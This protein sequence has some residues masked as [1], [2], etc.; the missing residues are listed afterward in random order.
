MT[1]KKK[2]PVSAS[3]PKSVPVSRKR[4]WMAPLALCVLTLLAFSNS[5]TNGFA[6]DS[7]MLLLGDP[8]IQQAIADNIGLIL[9]H[10]YW[11]PNGEAGL[12]RPLATLSYLFNYAVLGNGNQ[13]AG[14]HWI[15]FFLH[16]ANVLLVL[17]LA[18]RLSLPRAFFFAA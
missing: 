4:T 15:N 14:Y 8:R 16:T 1:A 12:Y 6:L 2:R 18:K 17:A 3:R 13:P 9:K 7:Q 10:T 5:F 11:W